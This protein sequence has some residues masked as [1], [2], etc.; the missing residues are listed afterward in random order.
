M[1]VP[2]Q[3]L[4]SVEQDVRLYETTLKHLA[5]A[6]LEQN[7]S[8]YPIFVLHR[9]QSGIT[10]GRPVIDANQ[11]N[12]QWSV[13]ASVAEEFLKKKIIQPT[14]KEEFRKIYKNPR[15]YACLFVVSG[16]ADAGFAFYPYH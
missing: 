14:K 16:E 13:N 12:S 2:E 4:E 3:I 10:L 9:E 6:V 15:K 11:M 7:I 5:D 8:K 1:N